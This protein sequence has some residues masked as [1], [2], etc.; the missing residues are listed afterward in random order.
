MDGNKIGDGKTS[1]FGNGQGAVTMAASG[2]NNFTTNPS[3]SGD[4]SGGNDFTKNPGGNAA[5]AGGRDFTKEAPQTQKSGEAPDLSSDGKPAGDRFA[6]R[7][8][9]SA[10]PDIGTGSSGNSHKPFK[11]SGK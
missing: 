3:G 11:L 8:P 2:G 4:K 10:S 1:P 7:P 9:L 5:R 6:V